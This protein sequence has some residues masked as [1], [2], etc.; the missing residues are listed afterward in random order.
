M[1]TS[2]QDLA[3]SAESAA[4]KLSLPQP[5]L[6][7]DFRISVKLNPKISVGSGPWGVRNWIS[8]TGGEWSATWA[9]GTVVSGGQDS[10]IV[11]PESGHVFVDTSYLLQTDDKDPAYITIKTNGWRT[12]SKQVMDRLAD[13]ALADDVKPDEYSFRLSIRLETGDARYKD[14]INTGLWIGSAA[15]LGSEVVYD[16]YRV[17]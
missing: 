9:K 8:F 16:A 1:P 17:S 5:S 7:L 4:S 12:G 3:L 2:D 10:Q 13:P 15:R 14:K 6:A 11:L